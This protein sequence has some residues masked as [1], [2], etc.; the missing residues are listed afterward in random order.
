MFRYY[1]KY[2]SPSDMYKEM[3]EID[4]EI[5]KVKLNFIKDDMANL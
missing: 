2:S 5:N 3:S 4:T 1:F